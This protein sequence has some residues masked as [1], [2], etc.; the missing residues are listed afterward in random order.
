MYDACSRGGYLRTGS[1]SVCVYVLVITA[2][3]FTTS[4]FQQM[5]VSFSHLTSKW[6]RLVFRPQLFLRTFLFC[7]CCL[8]PFCCLSS[9]LLQLHTHT[10]QFKPAPL[11][12]SLF[13]LY[14]SV[15]FLL[16]GVGFFHPCISPFSRCFCLKTLRNTQI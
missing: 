8:P 15:S 6:R 2:C 14:L 10:P 4:T 7:L 11:S 3:L 13:S 16:E 9:Y 5:V 12:V 1:V